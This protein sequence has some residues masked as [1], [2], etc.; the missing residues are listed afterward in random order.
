MDWARAATGESY[1]LNTDRQF[2]RALRTRWRQDADLGEVVGH[3][4]VVA[5]P[6]DLARA[7]ELADRDTADAVGLV[8]CRESRGLTG[9]GAEHLPFQGVAVAALL[10]A[11][12]GERVVLRSEER[13]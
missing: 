5:V 6:L 1:R 4:P 9:I 13:R 8:R 10:F 3:V 2:G 12:R 7:V 11:D